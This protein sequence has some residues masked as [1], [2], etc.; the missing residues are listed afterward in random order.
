MLPAL[1]ARATPRNVAYQSMKTVAETSLERDNPVWSWSCKGGSGQPKTDQ[2]AGYKENDANLF[3]FL[4]MV[5]PTA[6]E[7]NTWGCYG[8]DVWVYA[9]EQVLSGKEEIRGNHW[10]DSV[11][12]FALTTDWLM[13]GNYIQ[14]FR[15]V[16]G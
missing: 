3:A 1:R 9:M 10:S 5:A 8:R 16:F 15:S 12:Q 11:T 2:S 14:Q 13:A 4:S 6:A 7:R